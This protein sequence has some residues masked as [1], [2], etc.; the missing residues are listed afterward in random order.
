MR[1]SAAL[2]SVRMC[3][4][5]TNPAATASRTRMIWQER[6]FLFIFDAGDVV[7]MMTERLSPIRV[8]CG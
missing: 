7:L 4:N 8:L 5:R 1:A 3:P 2:Y 6:C